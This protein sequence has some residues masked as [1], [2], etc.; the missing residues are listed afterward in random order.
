MSEKQ[1][2]IQDRYE[3]V[4]Y[5]IRIKGHLHDRWAD[6]FGGLSISR[7]ENGNTLLTG[8]VV[9][10]SALYG[11]LKKVRD[12]GMPLVSV[13]PVNSRQVNVPDVKSYLLKEYEMDTNGNTETGSRTGE[14]SLRTAARI[15]GTGL[16]VMFVA[17]M[18][19]NFFMI[20]G[21]I[22]PGEAETTLNNI[23]ANQLL[24]RLGIVSFLIVLICDVLVAWALY[25]FFRPASTSLSVLAAWLRLVYTAIFGAA[26]LALVAVLRL[27][28]SAD[29]LAAFEPTE[30]QAQVMLFL[31]AFDSGWLFS[32][33]FFGVHL[34]ALGYLVLRSG[35]APKLLGIL[36]ITASF[37]YLLD[38]FAQLLLLNYASYESI[39][40]IIVAVPGIIGEM[41][42]CFW[43]LFKGG[44][45]QLPERI[46]PQLSL[47][48]TDVLK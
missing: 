48:P 27:V 29:L 24:F 26:V 45:N 28:S 22:V 40:L 20:E 25:V 21:L 38:S 8:P 9:D 16:L 15:A 36:L 34:F 41:S 19:A 17:A 11:L 1:P 37:G 5:E 30:L 6:W 7:E 18:F 23:M 42:L 46:S 33:V 35:Y 32:L 31:N 47:S 39:F 10:Q 4:M 2:S 12:V 43:L 14:V 44:K 3:S 13:N